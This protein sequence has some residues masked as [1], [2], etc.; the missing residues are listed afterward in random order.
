MGISELVSSKIGSYICASGCITLIYSPQDAMDDSQIHRMSILIDL[1]TREV[2]AQR[3]RLNNRS[4]AAEVRCLI[5]IGLAQQSGEL[6]R[7]VSAVKKVM[8][9]D[10]V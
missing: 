8:D 2:I 7:M 5:E 6:M 3:A 10:H 9:E 4:M 1:D